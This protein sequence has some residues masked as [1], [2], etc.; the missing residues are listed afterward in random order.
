VTP[1]AVGL[2]N[3]GAAALPPQPV[4]EMMIAAHVDANNNLE[5]T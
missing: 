5:L 2:S 4:K 1:L 3:V